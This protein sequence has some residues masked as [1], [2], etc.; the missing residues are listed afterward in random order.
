MQNHKLVCDLL[1]LKDISRWPVLQDFS[2]FRDDHDA[3]PPSFTSLWSYTASHDFQ[4]FAVTSILP[5]QGIENLAA[6][7]A[8][9]TPEGFPR[10]VE[11]F[12]G[13]DPITAMASHD[14]PLS[15]RILSIQYWLPD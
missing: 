4:F 9:P 2:F 7:D 14:R 15:L 6:N 10:A 8:P 5:N 11:P 3:L 13:H 12:I 1:Y